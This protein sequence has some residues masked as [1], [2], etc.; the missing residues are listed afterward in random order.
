MPPPMSMFRAEF[1]DDILSAS[2]KRHNLLVLTQNEIFLYDFVKRSVVCQCDIG[3]LK[4]VRTFDV[5]LLQTDT[6]DFIAN[7]Y[8]YTLSDG[9]LKC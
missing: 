5:R 2:R 8:R 1:K 3:V 9:L 6:I 7:K 4:G